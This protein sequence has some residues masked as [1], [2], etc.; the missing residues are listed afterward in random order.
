MAQGGSNAGS[1]TTPEIKNRNERE[2][3]RT[4]IEE[5]GYRLYCQKMDLEQRIRDIRASSPSFDTSDLEA[6]KGKKEAKIRELA[7]NWAD[8]KLWLAEFHDPHQ[9]K[10]FERMLAEKYR[11]DKIAKLAKSVE[12]TAS[13]KATA[14]AKSGRKQITLATDVKGAEVARD[15][16]GSLVM[17]AQNLL[18]ATPPLNL[19]D[20]ISGNRREDA[21][22]AVFPNEMATTLISDLSD[23]L[24]PK[25]QETLKTLVAFKATLTG[26]YKD[27]KALYTAKDQ[28]TGSTID[29]YAKGKLG[30]VLEEVKSH[31]GQSW[32]AGICILGALAW[33]K[34]GGGEKSEGGSGKGFLS[35][36]GKAV[37]WLL[38]IAGVTFG[39]DLLS[40]GALRSGLGLTDG[41]E[42][43]F[44]T[45]PDVL[46][47]PEIL[48]RVRASIKGDKLNNDAVDDL[49]TIIPVSA[50]SVAEAFEAAVPY[51][52][53]IDKNKFA[54]QIGIKA[55]KQLEGDD[56]YMACDWAF[57]E[58]GKIALAEDN[59]PSSTGMSRE[60]I[61]LEGAKYVE[62]RFPGRSFGALLIEL[63]LLIDTKAAQKGKEAVKTRNENRITDTHLAGLAEQFPSFRSVLRSTGEP[64]VY[65]IK[66]YPF[67]YYFNEK[68]E[69]EFKDCLNEDEAPVIFK[70]NLSKDTLNSL[71][72]KFA[73]QGEKRMNEE[74]KLKFSLAGRVN[75][76][77]AKEKK[78]VDAGDIE[79]TFALN[80][81]IEYLT[82]N[83]DKQ[84]VTADDVKSYVIDTA[85][86]NKPKI[87]LGSNYGACIDSAFNEANT[88]PVK[89]ES[90]RYELE[91]VET[92]GFYK[93]TLP[94][95]SNRHNGLPGYKP[96]PIPVIVYADTKGLH[97]GLDAFKDF[98]PDSSEVPYNS[99][100][101]LQEAYDKQVVIKNLVEDTAGHL[102]SG[103]GY[104]IASIEENDS[105]SAGVPATIVTISYGRAGLSTAKFEYSND[106]LTKVLNITETPE[107]TA[108]WKAQAETKPL[109]SLSAKMCKENLWKSHLNL[110]L[111]L[112]RQKISSQILAAG[113]PRTA[114]KPEYAMNER[115]HW[116]KK[117]AA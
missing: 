18:E 13:G 87:E 85:S 7:N 72:S 11:N 80:A 112:T 52:K 73:D 82:K 115:K 10:S 76:A 47:T 49:L 90:S 103:I 27:L 101:A 38:G 67:K 54:G 75:D 61:A 34:W 94:L 74:F 50:V 88:S 43:L 32:A 17:A 89:F 93:F 96:Q 113:Q 20:L 105:G 31:P 39:A 35:K 8:E 56:L 16:E 84:N 44:G 109:H 1:G 69:H 81:A 117:S 110:A 98:E 100:E 92:S 91:Y 68:G 104:E 9:A 51:G 95:E 55:M 106:K 48:E 97:L 86:A 5:T 45:R 78:T 65:R 24:S 108:L 26:P 107:L 3:T 62:K 33:A 116:L 83:S 60:D 12:G 40:K 14:L 57:Y 77:L 37:P 53:K 71:L 28:V 111:G 2:V 29:G 64:E 25:Y 102:L 21:I 79:K 63:K 114:L 99:A 6:D 4:D 23:P 58:C 22:R 41:F 59:A 30:S 15:A 42:K 70:D 66:G 19:D 46:I 36:I